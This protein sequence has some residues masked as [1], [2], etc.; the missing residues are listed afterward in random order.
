MLKEKEVKDNFLNIFILVF[1][2]GCVKEGFRKIWGIFRVI[3]VKDNKL[4][5]FGI[6]VLLVLW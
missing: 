3:F 6:V 5:R 2:I 4:L 1:M